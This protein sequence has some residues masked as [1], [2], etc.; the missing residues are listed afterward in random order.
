MNIR[1]IKH[2]Q[3]DFAKWDKAIDASSTPL[4]YAYSWYLNNI[5]NKQWDALIFGDYEAVF[6]IPYKRKYGLKYI[7]QPFFCQQLGVFAP[8][9]IAVETQVFLNAIPR[10]FIWVDMQLN[11]HHGQPHRGLKKIN[12][13]LNLN[14]SYVQI[15]ANYNPDVSKNIRKVDR[16]DIVYKWGI[17]AKKVIKINRDAWGALNP[18][19]N[20]QHYK[21]LENNCNEAL[22]KGQ[23]ITLGAFF[24]DEILGAVLFFTTPGFLFYVNGGATATGKKYGIMNGLIDE[25]IKRYAGKPLVLDFE[26]SEIEGVAYFY[27]KF[28][29]EIVPY[30]HYKKFNLF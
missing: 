26:G 16:Q 8:A 9:Q 14:Q 5:A 21:Q 13:Q 19:L 6:P 18:A 30:W 17:E 11:L 27:S 7:Y 3:I 22:K 28:G 4:I 25:V 29:S 20:D 15:L 12:Y 1:H 23:L 24:E 10:S 2:Q